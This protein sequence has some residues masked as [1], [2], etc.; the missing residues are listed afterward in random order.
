MNLT[1]IMYMAMFTAVESLCNS[2]ATILQPF[3]ELLEAFDSFKEKLPIIR[4]LDI[5]I[6]DLT[7][8]KLE[9]REAARKTLI[10]TIIP[11]AEICRA[12]AK[13]TKN[14]NLLEIVSTTK[15]DLKKERI[16]NLSQRVG[17]ILGA[18]NANK[19]ALLAFGLTEVMISGGETAL[20]NFNNAQAARVQMYNLR[21]AKIAKL[22][23]LF[24]E[25]REF[26]DDVIDREMMVIAG[27]H[28]DEYELY[29]KTRK[30]K[31][32]PATHASPEEGE[33]DMIIPEDDDE[34]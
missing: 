22:E 32:Y 11:M 2:I 25:T 9:D 21:S 4:S 34:N 3:P 30:L 24:K 29:K 6:Q 5:E 23:E 18:I 27:S 8:G 7:K 16:A 26:L 14:Y 28:P 15:S 10:E 1:Q 31:N 12:Y 33:P 19:D 20:V 13:L 17:D